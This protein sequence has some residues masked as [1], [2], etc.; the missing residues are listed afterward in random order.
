MAERVKAWLKD[1]FGASQIRVRGAAQSDGPS[2]VRSVSADR[3]PWTN[4]SR[5]EAHYPAME[6]EPAPS[7]PKTSEGGRRSSLKLWQNPDHF[8]SP[9]LFA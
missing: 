2:D 3:G 5:G 4:G 1:E 9:P 6:I 7:G 8:E